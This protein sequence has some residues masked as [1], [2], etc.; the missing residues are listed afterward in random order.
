MI[1]G[2]GKFKISGHSME[3]N[4]YE[5]DLVLAFRFLPIKTRDVI[6]F[7]YFGK[8]LIKRVKSIQDG[9]YFLEG[10][11]KKDT[12]PVGKILKKDIIG[13]VIFKV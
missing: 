2:F 7:K 11:N 6:V 5:G 1:F 9:E 3:P 8:T 13:K 4:F 12:L 10:D